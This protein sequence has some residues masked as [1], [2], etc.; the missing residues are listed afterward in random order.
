MG[1]SRRPRPI[2][3]AKKLKQIRLHL[4]LSQEG[5]V[6]RLDYKISPLI[7]ADI[8]SFENDKKEPPVQLILQYV[9]WFSVKRR[10]SFFPLVLF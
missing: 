2:R 1:R 9:S 3:L 5:M 4:N 7:S 10:N 8:S 6:K